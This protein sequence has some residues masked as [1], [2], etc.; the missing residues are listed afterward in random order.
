M[1]TEEQQGP[2]FLRPGEAGVG[3]K[4]AH[5]PHS[6]LSLEAAECQ[7]DGPDGRQSPAQCASPAPRPGT[8]QPASLCARPGPPALE[9]PPCE[10]P[11]RTLFL[12]LRTEGGQHRE[13]EVTDYPSHIL[14]RVPLPAPSTR[15]TLLSGS[16][17]AEGSSSHSLLR[18]AELLLGPGRGERHVYTE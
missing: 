5:L 1:K 9:L 12:V 14:P 4:G 11:N 7:W 13:S 18:A 17:P 2:G 6:P 16:L 8:A 10:G 3:K 15:S